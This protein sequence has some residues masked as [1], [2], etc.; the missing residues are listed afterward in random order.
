[1]VRTWRSPTRRQRVISFFGV[2]LDARA[3][4]GRLTPRPGHAHVNLAASIAGR[5]AGHIADRVLIAGIADQP[6][7]HA[8]NSRTRVLAQK[9]ASGSVGILRQNVAISL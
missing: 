9:L 3:Q 6:L 8:F 2:N 1:M 5:S 7:I 4:V